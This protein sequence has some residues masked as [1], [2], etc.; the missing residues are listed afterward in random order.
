MR[1]LIAATAAGRADVRA[2]EQRPRGRHAHPH[3]PAVRGRQGEHGD[4]HARNRGRAQRADA[5]RRLQ[6]ARHP[7]SALAGGGLQGED[8]AAPAPPGEGRQGE[9]LARRVLV[10]AR[11]RQGADLVRRRRDAARRGRVREAGQVGEG[12][13]STIRGRSCPTAACSASPTARSSSSPRISQ[14]R[15]ASSSRRTRSSS[16]STIG[17]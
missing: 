16:T 4:G 1:E 17:T 15:M 9:P 8:V 14:A 7:R 12:S 3:Q 2:R 6:G 13:S 10:R 5:L 11:R